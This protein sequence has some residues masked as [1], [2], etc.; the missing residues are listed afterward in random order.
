MAYKITD[1]TSNAKLND[2][3]ADVNNFFG[4]YPT[5]QAQYGKGK[6]PSNLNNANNIIIKSNNIHSLTPLIDIIGKNI[7]PTNS[8]DE[9][10]NKSNCWVVIS[11]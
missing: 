2:I 9:L 10:F 11:Y 5:S 3:I 4:K 8:S 1:E 6:I 7:I